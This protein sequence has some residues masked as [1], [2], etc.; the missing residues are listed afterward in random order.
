MAKSKKKSKPPIRQAKPKPPSLPNR[1]LPQ[2]EQS[3]GY[4]GF[5]FAKLR[6]F[7]PMGRKR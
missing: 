7:S 6:P 1:V 4:E 5:P 2:E 3:P